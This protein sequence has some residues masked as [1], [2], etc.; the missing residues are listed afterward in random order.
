MSE[1]GL[2]RGDESRRQAIG[3][4]V[5]K[6]DKEQDKEALAQEVK[7]IETGARTWLTAAPEVHAALER[8]KRRL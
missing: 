8:A 3:R 7:R 1:T 6:L 2:G 5:T 4:L